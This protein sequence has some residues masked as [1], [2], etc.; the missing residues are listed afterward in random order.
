[1]SITRE[2]VKPGQTAL[3]RLVFAA[4]IDLPVPYSILGYHP[5]SFT[6]S[7]SCLF[8]E[9]ELGRVRLS[10]AEQKGDRTEVHTIDLEDVHLFA[11]VEGDVKIDIDAL[12]DAMLGGAIDDTDVTTLMLFRWQGEWYGAAMGY[13]KDRHGRSGI[14]SLRRDKILFPTPDG[15]RGV[16]RQMRTKAELLGKV[17]DATQARLEAP[18]PDQFSAP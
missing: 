4:P 12:V 17:W 7:Q 10:E 2:P 16:G 14:L 8:R 6:A 5:G 15:L 9:W 18:V 13:G 1:L 3:V 11:A